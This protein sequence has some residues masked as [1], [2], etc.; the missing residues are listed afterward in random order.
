MSSETVFL[1]EKRVSQDSDERFIKLS[2]DLEKLKNE[3]SAFH[4]ECKKEKKRLNKEIEVLTAQLEEPDDE[5]KLR[6]LEE[7]YSIESEKLQNVKLSLAEKSREYARL[8]RT[9]DDIPSRAEL[10]QYQKRLIEL[11]DQSKGL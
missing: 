11:Y 10:N 9:L 6:E 3:K 5:Q 4:R 8:Q 1:P 7:E 2:Q